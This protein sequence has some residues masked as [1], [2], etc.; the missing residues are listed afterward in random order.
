MK[1]KNLLGI[2]R[3]VIININPIASVYLVIE[4]NIEKIHSFIVRVIIL[5]C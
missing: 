4:E 1:S 5:R 2:V 3:I